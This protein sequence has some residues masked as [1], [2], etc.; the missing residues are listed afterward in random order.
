VAAGQSS[1][2][3]AGSAPG[4]LSLGCSGEMPAFRPALS[5]CV[6]AGAEPGQPVMVELVS[7]AVA[8]S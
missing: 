6:Q 1:A 8:Q 4:A 2:G 7:G 5:S 3:I